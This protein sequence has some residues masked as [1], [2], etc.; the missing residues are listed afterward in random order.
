MATAPLLPTALAR[1]HL[2][3]YKT[4]GRSMLLWSSEMR[5]PEG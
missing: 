3:G 4:V 1:Y 2:A 5:K